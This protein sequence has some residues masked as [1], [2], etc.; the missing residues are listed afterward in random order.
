[1][2]SPAADICG[3]GSFNAAPEAGFG[4]AGAVLGQCRE[5]QGWVTCVAAAVWEGRQGQL[6]LLF[7]PL[8]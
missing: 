6:W 8:N 4:Q 2:L 3:F 1:M 7:I 5:H